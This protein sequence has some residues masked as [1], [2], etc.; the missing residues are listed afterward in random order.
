V[1]TVFSAPNYCDMYQNQAAY[2]RLYDDRFEFAQTD[3]VDHPFYLPSFQDAFA[4]SM[5]HLLEHV[6]NFAQFVWE[7]MGVND[8]KEERQEN[9]GATPDEQQ[10]KLDQLRQHAIIA[11]AS[12]VAVRQR[13]E[14]ILAT[15]KRRA[16]AGFDQARVFDRAEEKRIPEEAIAANRLPRRRARSFYV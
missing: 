9:A 10:R 5:P 14:E 1:V 4:F 15:A 11:R 16:G 7:E 13:Q 3:W 2:L 8:R 6:S 12:A